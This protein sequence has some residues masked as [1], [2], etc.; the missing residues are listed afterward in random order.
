M[1]V[2]SSEKLRNLAVVGHGDT[3]KTTL[4]SALLYTGGVVNRLNRVEDGSTTTDFDNEEIERGTSIGLATCFVSWSGHKINLID[5]P[6]S[7]IFY[8]EARA[9]MRAAD[10]ALLC[11]NG[12]AGI[13]VTTENL[14]QFAEEIGLPVV[15]HL[16]QMDRERADAGTNLAALQ[17][18][19]GRGVVPVQLP[20]GKEHD[21]EGVIDLIEEKAYRFAKDGDGKA[22]PEEIPEEMQDEASEAR[23]QLVEMVAESSDDLMEKFFEDGTLSNED[24]RLGLRAAIAQRQV[25]P[26]TLG[27][28]AHGLGSA[29]L[30]DSL[31]SLAP[32]PTDRD[33]FPAENVAGEPLELDLAAEEAPSAL[34]FKTVSDPYSGKI[35]LF[36]VVSGE[37]KS[38]SVAWNST[39]EEAERIGHLM[40]MQGKQQIQ[41]DRLLTGDIGALTKLKSAATGDTL[42]TKNN[43]IRLG[44]IEIPEPAISFAIEPKSKGDE[45]KIG[46]ALTKII[47]EDPTLSSGRDPE[48]G[49]FLLSGAGQLHVEITVSK[50][51]NRFGVDVILHPPKVPYREAILRP[52]DGHGRHKKQTGGRGQFADCR[53]K[54]E[55]L[56]RGGDFEFVDEIFGGSIPQ[57]YRP[58]VKKGIL[59]TRQRGYLAGYPIVDFRVRL[60]DGQYHDV[61]SSEMAFKI[62]GSMAFKDALAKA[63]VTILEPVMQVQVVTAEDFTGDIIGDLSQRRGKPQGME[64]KNEVQV[65]NAVV[66]MAEMLNYA[67]ALNS[68]TQGR[69]S[70]HMSY[71]HY[72]EVPRQIQEKIIAEAK[73]EQEESH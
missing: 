6:G 31:V 37:L 55:P 11:I 2:D 20:I 26:V 38:D 12:V 49:E 46:E 56:P 22:K 13:E 60:V 66:P 44:W 17:E 53:I 1:Q 63:G 65:V 72:E 54:V 19:F 69:A 39:K 57:G 51:H 30:L 48:T 36:R 73:R 58:A 18:R 34:V 4:C 7:A 41:V 21:F 24:L 10:A 52:A 40:A 5:C 16:T 28:A 8:S 42:A 29:S 68:M 32:A 3:G 27:S 71:S 62:A 33:S 15:I 45:D 25:F 43:P 14:W 23:G 9:G 50:L 67:P 47:E 70:F 61:D 59:E 35:S 64:S